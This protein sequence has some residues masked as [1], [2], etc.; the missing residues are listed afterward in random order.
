MYPLPFTYDPLFW[1]LAC[2]VQINWITGYF[3]WKAVK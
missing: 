2:N 1:S 3:H